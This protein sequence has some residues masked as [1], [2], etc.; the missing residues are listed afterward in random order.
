MLLSINGTSIVLE[1]GL[2]GAWWKALTGSI[3]AAAEECGV[4]GGEW[5][6]EPVVEL[7]AEH[8]T[9]LTTS[10]GQINNATSTDFDVSLDILVWGDKLPHGGSVAPLD[11]RPYIDIDMTN[12]GHGPTFINTESYHWPLTSSIEEYKNDAKW[13]TRFGLD[14][15]RVNIGPPMYS[16]NNG[17]IGPKKHHGEPTWHTLS[18]FC[19]EIADDGVVCDGIRTNSRQMMKELG[20]YLASEG[21]GGAF[22]W[23]ADYDTPGNLSLILPLSQ[24]MGL[25]K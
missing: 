3:G 13:L 19:P 25:S 4:Q 14:K 17:K 2:K 6:Y 11:W 1:D 24:G 8:R 20:E 22:P 9:K 10:L 5:D 15:S 21:W 23:A 7:S 12:A 16:W 18:P